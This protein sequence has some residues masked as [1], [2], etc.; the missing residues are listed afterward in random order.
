VIR[1]ASALALVLAL[2]ACTPAT[3]APTASPATNASSPPVAPRYRYHE[4]T[5]NLCEK[6]DLGPIAPLRLTVK[7]KSPAPP[8]AGPG[9]ACLFEATSPSG[10]TSSLRVEAVVLAGAEDARRLYKAQR[11]V[12]RMLPDAPITALGDEAEGF[13][14]QTTPGFSYAEYRVHLRQDNLVIEVWLAVGGNDFVPKATLQPMA[15]AVAAATLST[16]DGA[17]QER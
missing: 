11:T 7:S 10:K 14:L 16:V 8:A 13:T 1:L 3:T 15:Q 6:S 17:W 4:G 12:T 9:E 2:T 5:I